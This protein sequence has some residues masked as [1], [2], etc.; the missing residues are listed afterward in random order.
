MR[1]TTAPPQSCPPRMI[2]FI[3][4]DKICQVSDVLGDAPQ[5]VRAWLTR[6]A[7][8]AETKHVWRD[9]LISM[10]LQTRDLI[11]PAEGQIRKSMQKD[12]CREGILDP[13][14]VDHIFKSGI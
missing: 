6:G 12:N 4:G 11:P 10:R 14:L 1:Q 2:F 9:D 13:K 8:K 7:G 5:G 3:F